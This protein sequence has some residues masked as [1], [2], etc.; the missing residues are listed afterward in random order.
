MVAETPRVIRGDV[1]WVDLGEPVG[2]EPGYRR[3]AVVLQSNYF[4]HS[5]LNTVIVVALSTN[6]RLTMYPG[7]LLLAKRKTGLPKDSVVNVTQVATVDQSQLFDRCG[8][9]DADS[10]GRVAEG[11]RQVLDL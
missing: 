11:V 4:N 6:L 1:W 8:H 3:P 7:N 10:M 2:S 9:L 5:E